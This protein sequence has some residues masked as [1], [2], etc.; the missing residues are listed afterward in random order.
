MKQP[1]NW[2]MTWITLLLTMHGM[3]VGGP[4]ATARRASEVPVELRIIAPESTVC[5]GSALTVEVDLRNSSASPLS[6]W[7]QGISAIHFQTRRAIPNELLPEYDSLDKN[8]AAT[9]E[10]IAPIV[11]QPGTSHRYSI[12]LKDDF[13]KTEGFYKVSLDY[14]GHLH[15]SAQA[16][17]GAPPVFDGRIES[18]WLIFEVEE[19]GTESTIRPSR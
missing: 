14:D 1:I 4:K 17:A 9:S 16:K 7:P 11:L 10:A 19:C 12:S 5:T 8:S 13:F 15:R 3:S 18:N 6:L 2:S